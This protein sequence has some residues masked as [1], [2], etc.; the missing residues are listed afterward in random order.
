MWH[1]SRCEDI[2][3]NMLVAGC[4]QVLHSGGWLEQMKISIRDTGN[5]MTAAEIAGFSAGVDIA[6]V[7]GYRSAVGRR[8]REIIQQLPPGSFKQKVDPARI[9]QV[10]AEG[11]VLET[12]RWLTD[13]W[14]SRTFAGLLK[15]PATRHNFVHLNEAMR[16]KLSSKP[17]TNK[18]QRMNE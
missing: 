12:T 2:T 16:L 3:M 5:A 10:L 17:S 4:P 14:G 13:Y 8:T 9:Q 7:R 1:T 6:A 15:M 11:A 18:K